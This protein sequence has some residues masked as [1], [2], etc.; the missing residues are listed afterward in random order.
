MCFSV[1]FIDILMLDD[2]AY[3]ESSSLRKTG[4]IKLDIFEAKLIRSDMPL[5]TNF[6]LPTGDKVHER[7][8]KGMNHQ[9]KQVIF[10]VRAF[11]CLIIYH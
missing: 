1:I 8:K 9:V 10:I 5:T 6:T 2:D 4:E 11:S 3:L 7:S